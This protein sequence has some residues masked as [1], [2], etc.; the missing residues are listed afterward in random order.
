VRRPPRARRPELTAR[1]DR[2][3]GLVSASARSV[4]PPR[5]PLTHARSKYIVLTQ[6]NENLGQG[7]RFVV[8]LFSSCMAPPEC[9]PQR[10]HGLPLGRLGHGRA[11]DVRQRAWPRSVFWAR[12]YAWVVQESLICVCIAF[13][14]RTG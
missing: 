13:A 9:A 14:V 2:A 1:R 5:P 7:G 12:P 4:R 8:C 11:G 6:I 3:A 10:G